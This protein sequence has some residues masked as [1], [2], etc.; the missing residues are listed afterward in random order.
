MNLKRLTGLLLIINGLYSLYGLLVNQSNLLGLNYRFNVLDLST[1]L[2]LVLA[3]SYVFSSFLDQRFFSTMTSIVTRYQKRTHLIRQFVKLIL[4][5][6]LVQA[7]IHSILLMLVSGITL[8]MM[9]IFIILL[10]SWI[11]LLFIFACFWLNYDPALAYVSLFTVYIGCVF[12]GSWLSL[13]PKL[14]TL[15]YLLVPQLLNAYRLKTISYLPQVLVSIGE[16]GIAL[17]CLSAL[18]KRYDF[19]KG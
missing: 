5:V 10:L 6:S 4:I 12:F 16:I 1:N 17:G 14:S 13:N 7:G 11:L 2:L 18:L 8:R 15:N 3:V 19:L 9:N